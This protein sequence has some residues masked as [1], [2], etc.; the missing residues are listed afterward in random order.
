MAIPAPD[1]ML[2][3]LHPPPDRNKIKPAIPPTAVP[4]A[5][6]IIPFLR[7]TKNAN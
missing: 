4:I 7:W 1:A 3:A 2:N 5:V 6:L